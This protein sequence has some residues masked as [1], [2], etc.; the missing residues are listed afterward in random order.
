MLFVQ[1]L[2]LITVQHQLTSSCE[3]PNKAKQLSK[4]QS[5]QSSST[6]RQVPLD[7]ILLKQIIAVASPFRLDEHQLKHPPQQ[8][9]RAAQ[10]LPSGA[11]LRLVLRL[12]L[13]CTLLR[14]SARYWS[15]SDR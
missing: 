7:I 5:P 13:V 2:A 15:Q 8:E 11:P 6:N 10:Q 12:V 4:L 1:S 9:P 3:H 14:A